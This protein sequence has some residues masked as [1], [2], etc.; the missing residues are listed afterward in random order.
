[1]H[2]LA[3]EL[4]QRGAIVREH[5]YARLNDQPEKDAQAWLHAFVQL[6]R[7]LVEVSTA[8]FIDSLDDEEL[9][10][11]EWAERDVDGLGHGMK[12]EMSDICEDLAYLRLMLEDLQH[13]IAEGRGFSDSNGH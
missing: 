4:H 11:A 13:A 1:M 3:N 6:L 10:A 7:L 9:S 5:A 8:L 2:F 12:S